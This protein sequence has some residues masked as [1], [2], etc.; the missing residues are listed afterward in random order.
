MPLRPLAAALSSLVLCLTLRG[1]TPEIIRVGDRPLQEAIDAALPYSTVLADR[2]RL[3]EIDATV[4]IGKPL[5]LV[6]LHARLKPGLEKTPI[7][8]IA[9]EGVRLRDFHL[10][11]N[12]DTVPQSGRAPLVHVRAG[13]FVIENGA[14]DNSAKDGVMI[15]PDAEFGDIEHGV[16]RNITSRNTIRDT[17]SIGGAAEQ[18]FYVRHLVVDNIRAYESELRGPVEVSDGSEY[19]TVRDVYAEGCAYG[20]DVQDHNRPQQINRHIVIES[21]HVKNTKIAVRMANHDFGHDGLTIRNVTAS[22]W[23]ADADRPFWVRNTSNALIENVRLYGCPAGPCI[24]VRNSDNLTLRNVFLIDGAHDG[25]AVLIE[26][27]DH[28][29]VDNVVVR[30]DRTPEHGVVYRISSNERFRGLR[31]HNVRAAHVRGTGVLI[32]NKSESGGLDDYRITGNDAAVQAD[33]PAARRIV[34]DNLP[35]TAR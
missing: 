24:H 13:G 10:I 3:L 1:E 28:A 14:T 33:E 11:G 26:D 16:V 21:V 2:G 17:V 18:G 8:E 31:I 4:R 20:V 27:S 12:G 9:S 25:P 29:F 6:G 7:L 22:D 5:T 30:G 23:P 35:A 19:V 15:T 32:E 34:R